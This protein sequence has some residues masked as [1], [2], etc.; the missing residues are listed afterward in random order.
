MYFFKGDLCTWKYLKRNR[1]LIQ[2]QAATELK[3]GKWD[4]LFSIEGY[5]YKEGIGYEVRIWISDPAE[6][7][8]YSTLLQWTRFSVCQSLSH[9]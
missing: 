5:V 9:N 7:K 8:P 6:G 4:G 1:D 2:T 3:M